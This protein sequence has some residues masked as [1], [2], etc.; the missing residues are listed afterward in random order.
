MCSV[1]SQQRS[2]PVRGR[3]ADPQLAH[4]IRAAVAAELAERGWRGVSVE[5]VAERAGVART[6]LYRRYGSAHGLLLLLM[7]DIYEQ[8]PVADTGTLRG[9]LIA[10]MRGV[11]KVWGD[12]AHVRYLSA[13]IT[14][15]HEN[16]ELAKAYS[17]QF[18]SRRAATSVLIER[19]VA[20]GE[21]TG[22]GDLLLDLL[23]G[24]VAQR[25]LLRRMSFDDALA[26]TVVDALLTGFGG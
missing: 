13:L 22:D 20:R 7:G 11:A 1:N 18:A 8:V 9:D 12:P 24:I 3:P 19:A 23:A 14:A 15:Q 16:P 2:R 6:T 10:L 5:R 4:V 25:V 21:F 26:E 17:D